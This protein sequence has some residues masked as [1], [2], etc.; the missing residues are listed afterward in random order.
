MNINKDL[1]FLNDAKHYY[2]EVGKKYLSNSD[3]YRLLREPKKFLEPRDTTLAML[4]GSYLHTSILEPH[5]L[6]DFKIVEASTRN[7]KLYKEAE[8]ENGG[9]RMLLL[10]E[11][12]ELDV[13][14]DAFLANEDFA[15]LLLEDSNKFEVPGILEIQDH[16]WK[17]KCD[18][19][20]DEL[21]IDIK[22]C[23]N[24][25]KFHYSARDYNYDS[26]AY[27]YNQIFGRPM[28]FLAIEKGSCRM[29]K[30]TCSDQFYIDGRNKVTKA[31]AIYD[32]YFAPK[33][34]GD[35]TQYYNTI[36]L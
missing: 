18:V 26:Q 8:E 11:A 12:Q 23:Q 5:R 28:I 31:L 17:G 32:E 22:T 7:T 3:I 16:L 15:E 20:G 19:I 14:S 35:I 25:D 10:K 1:I 36:E 30:F 9:E 2:G 24:I 33:A 6:T 29:N 27:I 21:I 13:L 34:K 4:Q